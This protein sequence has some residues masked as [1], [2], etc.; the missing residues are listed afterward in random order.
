MRKTIVRGLLCLTVDRDDYL[1]RDRYRIATTA[2]K[3][4]YVEATG[5]VLSVSRTS[6]KACYLKVRGGYGWVEPSVLIGRSRFLVKQLM[7]IPV[8]GR[9]RSAD[10]EKILHVNGKVGDCRL[11]NI[12]VS[13]EPD[14]VDERLGREE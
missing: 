8:F 10:P 1:G 11:C 3:D 7:A 2:R 14:E 5:K 13:L 12:A 9:E 6:G 4:Y